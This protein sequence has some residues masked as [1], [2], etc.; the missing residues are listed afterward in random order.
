MLYCPVCK[1][2]IQPIQWLDP[3]FYG[4]VDILDA[5]PSCHQPLPHPEPAAA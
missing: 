4:Q 3:T 5:C 1:I 2:W